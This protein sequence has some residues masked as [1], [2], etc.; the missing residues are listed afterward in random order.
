MGRLA[1]K[2]G[3]VA[4]HPRL[5]SDEDAPTTPAAPEKDFRS[6]R[7]PLWTDNKARLIREYIKLFTYVT[8]HGA[9][10]DGFAAPQRQDR[11]DLCSAKLVL[12]AEPKRIRELWLC[13]NDPAGIAI[14]T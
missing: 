2:K 1:A 6:L 8:K 4:D 12:E 14:L 13:D 5:F 7:H 11:L 9:Y 10:I 3:C